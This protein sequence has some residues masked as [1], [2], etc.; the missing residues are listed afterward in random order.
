MYL[1]KVD[2]KHLFKLNSIERSSTR[3]LLFKEALGG[4]FPGAAPDE[5]AH[6]HSVLDIGCGPGTWGTSLAQQLYPQRVRVVGL[7]T[8][9]TMVNFAN[10]DVKNRNI[11]SVSYVHVERLCGPFEFLPSESFDIIS[12]RFLSFTLFPEE[13]TALVK[14]CQRL[15]RPGGRLCLTNSD[16]AATSNAP[17][18]GEMSSLFLQAIQRAGMSFSLFNTRHL[19]LVNELKP[20][21][22]QNGFTTSYITRNI[23]YSYGKPN[24]REWAHEILLF[25]QAVSPFLVE[26]GVAKASDIDI[27]HLRQSQEMQTPHFRA[28]LPILT[29]W[30]KK[31]E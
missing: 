8:R 12:G 7:D 15:L 20:P 2:R 16:E 25:F 19:G 13:W 27:L 5:Y 11:E 6:V 29:L 28:A 3:T 1:Q 26:M 30:G 18:H 9:E 14:E 23:N 4:F 31:E 22:M 17:A 10:A 24:A 21:L